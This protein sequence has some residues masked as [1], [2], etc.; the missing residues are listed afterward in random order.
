MIRTSL[1][2]GILLAI[3]YGTLGEA[4]AG[5]VGTAATQER[6]FSARET[7]AIFAAE[8]IRR[9][10][11]L[12]TRKNM[13]RD[14]QRKPPYTLV[15]IDE[16]LAA[17][18]AAAAAQSLEDEIASNARG[19]YQGP[20]TFPWI[21]LRRSYTDVL[22]SEDP[23]QKI[24]GDCT[25]DDLE[26]ALLSFSRD[27]LEDVD[28]WSA[29]AAL[30]APFSW[31]TGNTLREETVLSLAR[32]G[33]I[34]SFTI[35]RISTSGDPADE[36]DEK[37]YRVGVFAKLESGVTALKAVTIRGF[38][39]YTADEQ[40]DA[41]TWAG[42]FE[43]E[44]Q[45]DFSQRLKLGY[46]SILIAK[47]KAQRDD[48]HDTAILAYQA[49]ALLHG[50]YGSVND[51][52]D[53]FKGT[54]YEY[55][56]LGPA[57]QFDLKPFFSRHVHV[58]LRYQYQP[59]LSGQESSETFGIDSNDSL[60]TA[61]AE[62]LIIDPLDTPGRRLSLKASYIKGGVGPTQKNTETLL[63]GLGAAF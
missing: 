29:Q 10:N 3:T 45:F 51:E 14:L 60:F 26:G 38:G 39:V 7:D 63:I 31:A 2:A 8:A 5:A 46:R 6:L 50:E 57:L 25:F 54:E 20:K 9:K 11:P 44:P 41:G 13:E 30:I 55:F 28:T 19:G 21:H 12:L 15:E 58:S 23:S 18:T 4:R 24:P 32:V 16:Y 56:R 47:P 48:I 17:A 40:H 59:T 42:E 33:V 62:W 52:G 49:R 53:K 34:P 27:F 37:A 43:V 35:N 36:V 1:S 61:D 22:A